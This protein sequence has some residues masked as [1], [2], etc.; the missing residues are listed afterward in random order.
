MTLHIAAA[1]FSLAL[2]VITAT[3]ANA[4]SLTPPGAPA[5]TMRT[6]EQ[7]KPTWDKIIPAAQRFVGALDGTAVL[8]KE[9][10]LVWERSTSATVYNWLDAQ[11]ICVQAGIGG[12]RGWRLPTIDELASLVDPTQNNPALPS[13]HLFTDVYAA[14]YWSSTAKASDLNYAWS[15]VFSNGVVFSFAKSSS[16]YVRCVRGG[17]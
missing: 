15:V 3:A 1:L 11:S 17:Q 2:A 12:R 16:Y 9:T 14:Y 7:I 8:D 5:P 6:M 4:G 13:G 10:G